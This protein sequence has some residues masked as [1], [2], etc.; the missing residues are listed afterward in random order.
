MPEVVS[1]AV[2]DFGCYEPLY[3]YSNKNTTTSQQNNYTLRYAP[4]DAGDPQFINGFKTTS[5]VS[6][7]RCHLSSVCSKYAEASVGVLDDAQKAALAK[8]QP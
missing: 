3:S 7:K 8:Q 2:V 1:W 4:G 5:F 6:P